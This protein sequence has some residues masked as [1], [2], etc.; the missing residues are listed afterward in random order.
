MLGRCALTISQEHGYLVPGFPT[1]FRYTVDVE[2]EGKPVRLSRVVLCTAKTHHPLGSARTLSSFASP[3]VIGAWSGG[4]TAIYA[5]V[6]D[7]CTWAAGRTDAE[8]LDPDYVP[9]LVRAPDAT[10]DGD[11]EV[12]VSRR[13]LNL[14]FIAYLHVLQN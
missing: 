4:D 8:P 1:Y 13:V 10:G 2:V 7:V 12:F 14:E 11:M 5:Y 9:I 3:G 6:P